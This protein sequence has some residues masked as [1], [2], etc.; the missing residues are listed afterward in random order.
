[1]LSLC[2]EHSLK[3]MLGGSKAAELRAA[4]SAL[5]LHLGWSTQ[6]AAAGLLGLGLEAGPGGESRV[7]PPVAALPNW[8]LSTT[9]EQIEQFGS[10]LR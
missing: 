1:M 5:Q 10:M 8:L 7:I 4:F 9:A 6:Q 3:I 2:R